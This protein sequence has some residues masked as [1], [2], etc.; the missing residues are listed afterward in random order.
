MKDIIALALI[1]RNEY[2]YVNKIGAS[3]HCQNHTPH[4]TPHPHPNNLQLFN[5][6]D[7]TL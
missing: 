3:L 6:I 1:D 5:M 7:F 2:G 4:P